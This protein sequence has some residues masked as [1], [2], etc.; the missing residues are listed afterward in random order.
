LELRT[1][2]LMLA[3]LDPARDAELLHEAFSDP[4]VMRWWNTPLRLD[5]ADTRRDLTNFLDGEG[6]HL[7]AVRDAGATVGLIGFLG[8]V[9]VPGLSWM[10]TRR[11][12]GRGLITEA[13][14]A[15]IDY[16]FASLGLCRVEAWIESTNRRSLSTARRVGLT[17]RGRLAQRYPHRDHP[18]ES[19]VL[20]RSRAPEAAAVLSVEVTIPVRNIAS[21]LG[22]L[23]SVFGARTQFLV[24]DPPT[25]A[26]VVF[27]QWSVGPGLRLAAASPPIPPITVSID[28]GTGFDECYGRAT[29]AEATIATAPI[30]QPWGLRE[31]ALRLSDGHHLVVTG[32]A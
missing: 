7:W 3:P 11:A 24:G 28:V 27:G 19:I 14:G 1:A 30:L 13:A 20:G 21:Q 25:L 9:A 6:A 16:A 29:A 2:R 5:V 18:H 26:G 17:E 23:R 22:L 8:D 15:V 32:P 31:F 12:W 10:L 4:D